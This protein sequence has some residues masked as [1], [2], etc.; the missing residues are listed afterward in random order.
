MVLEPQRL[1]YRLLELPHPR[2]YWVAYSGGVDSHVLLHAL[3]AQRSALRAPLHAVH[4]NHGLQTEAD[5]WTR[6]CRGVC[7]DLAVPLHE[8]CIDARPRRGESPEARAREARYGAFRDWL[9][10]GAALLSAHH[11]DDQA[12]T[13]LLQALR[14]GGPKGLA[15]MPAASRLGQGW[16]LR[17]LLGWGRAA[18]RDYARAQGLRWAEDPSNQDTRFDRNYLRHEILPRLLE[19]WPGAGSA[20]SRSARHCSEAA[21]LLAELAEQDLAGTAGARP[22][23]LSCSRVSVLSAARARN[24]LRHWLARQGF[25]APS[26]K[27]LTRVLTEA[28]AAGSEAQPQITWGE[29]E[30]RR[31]RDDLFA[32]VARP[33]RPPW[34]P[35]AF[36]EPETMSLPALGGTLTVTPTPGRGLRPGDY[37]LHRRRGGERCRPAGRGHRHALKKLF[38]E[39][40]VPPW[41]RDHIPLIYAGDTIAAVPGYCVCE[42]FA[43]G[44]E[45]TGWVLAWERWRPVAGSS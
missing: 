12:E 30:V 29:A 24:L 16:L 14:G 31:Y 13:L 15:G 2:G 6:H 5:V 37:W 34:E 45:E 8:L 20:L 23:T 4:V 36:R 39:W 11:Q 17:P 44:R 19:R 35:L 40:G 10:A 32:L 9:P 43:V 38:Q 26:E 25:A 41:E 3:A 18:I 1:V 42:G 22:D 7:E 33:E 21:E 28:V 27:V